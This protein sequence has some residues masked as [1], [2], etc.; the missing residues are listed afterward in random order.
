TLTPFKHAFKGINNLEDYYSD[1]KNK[2]RE[3]VNEWTRTSGAFDGIID[4]DKVIRDP[5]RVDYMLDKY[6]SGDNLHPN[7]LGYKAMADAIDL[8]LLL[9]K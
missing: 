3:E 1:E 6:N 2:A 7:D 5:A 8:K 9:R 4:F